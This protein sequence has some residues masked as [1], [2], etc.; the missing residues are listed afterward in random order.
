MKKSCTFFNTYFKTGI[1][2]CIAVILFFSGYKSFGQAC[3]GSIV[4]DASSAPTIDGIIDIAWAKA[5]ATQI[6][7]LVN[8]TLQSDYSAQWRAMY[9]NSF[10]YV[11]IEVKDAGLKHDGTP[12]DDDAIEI[13]VDGAHNGGA[14]YDANDFKFGFQLQFPTLQPT[15]YG[16]G[17]LAGVS[18]KMPDVPGGYLLE[19]AIP[20]STIGGVATSGRQIGFDINIHDD[21]N[22]GPKEATSGWF[23]TSNQL[24]VNPG[25]FGTVTL[26][27]CVNPLNLIAAHTDPN[28]GSSADGT[29]TLSGSNGT[30]PYTYS[31]DGT[32]FVS[33]GNFT[34]L[35]AGTYKVAVKDGTG[36]RIDSTIILETA[37]ST[38]KVNNDTT[39]CAGSPVTLSVSGGGTY[40]WTASP[41]D[42][43]LTATSSATPTVSPI[44]TTTYTVTSPT[45]GSN[46]IA[47]SGFEGG[48]TG[49]TTDYT[50][51]TG[52]TF[53]SQ[54]YSI[55]ANPE[56]QNSFFTTCGDHTTGTGK[57]M[58]IDGA[59][60]PS[61]KMWRQSVPV[62]PN[63]NYVFSY[64]MQTV[65]DNPT[66]GDDHPAK[67]DTK[68][69]GS[70][71]GVA[72]SPVMGLPCGNW[73][74]KI[75]SWNSGA[76]TSADIII[77]DLETSAGGN[78]FAID[79]ISFSTGCVASKT[80]TITI[81]VPVAPSVSVTQPDCATPTGA[82]K[83]T[84]T[85]AGA[86]YSFNDGVSFQA[87]PTSLPLAQNATY[88]V[89]VKNA[90]GCVSPATLVT[91]ISQ[92]PTPA[93]P[94][95]DP[96]QPTCT[97]STGSIEVTSIAVGS[98]YSFDNG[99]TFQ[100]SAISSALAANT[101]YQVKVQNATGCISPAS[102][103]AINAQPL[104][105]AAPSATP[106]QPTCTT[107]T[108]TIEVTSIAAGLTYSFDNG[109][110][111][112]ASSISDPLPANT[113]YQVKVKN[114]AGC[115]SPARSVTLNAQP[116]AIAAPTT[117]PTHPTCTTSTGTIEVTS[118]ATGLT[119]SFDNGINFQASAISSALNGGTTYQAKVKNASGC[120]SPATP[121]T[122]NAQPLTPSAPTTNPTQPTCTTAT[123]TIEVTSTVVGST[124]SFDNGINFKSSAISNALNGG[125]T[126]Q[127][128]VKNLSGCISLAS[129]VPLNAQ[130]LTPLAPA[131]DP[132]QPTCTTAQGIIEVT[133]TAAGSTYSFDNGINFQSSSISNALNGGTTYQVKI[134]NASGCISPAA[135]V[136]LNAQPL[137]PSAP[138]TNPT[139][140][141][142]TTATGTIE[143]TSTAVGSTYSFDNGINFQASAI[144][145]ALNGG[146]TYQVK[147]KT[148]SGCISPASSVA[149]NNAPAG[150]IAPTTNPIHPTCTMATGNIEVT[151]IAAGSSYSFDNGINF[152]SSAIS[153]ALPGN[154]IY[155]VKIKNA[156]GCISPASSVALNAQPSTP[157]APTTNLV[158]PTCTTTTGTI[159]VTSIAAGSSYSFDNGINFQSSAI[160]NALP[161]N[162]TY[163][164]KV[165]NTAG[166][167]SPASSVALNA[168]P[169]TPLAPT[170][171]KTDPTCTTPT[172][173]IEVTSTA[174]GSTYSFDNGINF[175]TS[176]ISSPLT[177][178]ATYQ[179]KVKNISGCISPATSV[180]LGVQPAP[181]SPPI[182]MP[183]QPIC[184]TFTGTIEVTSAAAGLTYSFDNGSNFQ[185]SSISNPLPGGA[186]YQ[187][188]VKTDAGCLS[189]ATPVTL[190]L[191][192]IPSAPSV[193]VNQ[194]TCTITTGTIEVTSVAT[195]LTYSFDNGI[196]FQSANI[197]NLLT[198][199]NT[200]QVIVKNNSG[201]LSAPT[202]ATINPQPLTPTAPATSVEEPN[203]TTSTGKITVTSIETGATYSFDN[204]VSFQSSAIS[205][206][207]TAG[208]SYQVKIKSSAGCISPA[209]TASISNAPASVNAPST[210]SV[211]YCQNETAVSLAT[212]A[213]GTN[214]KW[215][216]NPVGGIGSTTAPTPATTAPLTTSYF[217]SQ[218]DGVCES[219]RAILTVMVTKS[220][221]AYAGGPEVRFIEGDPVRLK[222][223]ASG[224][225]ITIKWSPDIAISSTS[226]VQPVVKPTTT[227]RY[228]MTV[229]TEGGCAAYDT[230]DVIL[231]ERV[232]IPNIFSP[233][234]D[235][236]YDKWIIDKI[237][238]YP[239]AH[240]KIFNRYGQLLS[241]SVGAIKPWDGTYQ[242][243]P[244]P[245]GAYYYVIKLKDEEV[246][247]GGSISLIR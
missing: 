200:Y 144:S 10:L 92:P 124:Y 57:M 17:S 188:K 168:Q 33:S 52:S 2:Y 91:L 89:K 103:V 58:V 222:G 55:N 29:M 49:F 25:L 76:S 77:Y 243:K 171:S 69:N 154:I 61:A 14:S 235:G 96:T 93:A 110:N 117:D 48:N 166:C 140:P 36:I 229:T 241:E 159:E 152:Q 3:T 82:I 4:V 239:T 190:V 23:S 213:S 172:G 157:L 125:T 237:D 21:D 208:V 146:S 108:G 62:I 50:Y 28:C 167:I 226:I 135:S 78:D 153:N 192:P 225:N 67:L 47:N 211:V 185:S 18:A 107:A 141:T 27:Q 191:L 109:A 128:K 64:W 149:L 189:S 245:V 41:A 40:T 71:L 74:Q 95:T 224:D 101:T 98:T 90:I 240:V 123:G 147:V 179:V 210:T 34:G 132:T 193:K 11:L 186:T 85:E 39:V 87:S 9:D 219:P 32:T 161:G 139:H 72:T 44:V 143:V 105:P 183:T 30:T 204:G 236:I 165:K 126:Y 145:N 136:S 217:V 178:G 13:F 244:V 134:K 84:S 233:N 8:G 247:I 43:T 221:V 7:K 114:A 158:H 231:V 118:T 1:K 127:V 12:S 6:T 227:I 163:Q 220:P 194:P 207:L 104:T 122:L 133:S 5:P 199:G 115:I 228:Y 113:T 130:P 129:S 156:A 175:Q 238:Q 234:G 209:M 131:T 42:P 56:I 26:T 35:S 20:W 198:A 120:I 79:D 205:S 112:Q 142:C 15:I 106:T 197:S 59:A 45:V 111:F 66:T 214:L 195:G 83:V 100:S 75:Y 177:G 215:Y 170:V 68:I 97:T 119:Y 155:Q 81:D 31:K 212:S 46:L 80:V 187:V 203:C 151:S 65:A 184:T 230:V 70:S 176:A 54:T 94:A 137:P 116:G 202:S 60:N 173:T 174:A 160:S 53:S 99:V 162:I 148:A 19:V 180:T 37:G 63:S 182:A 88:K 216:T 121:T 38:L 138:T 223:N 218:S 196:N 51:T 24:S 73:V 102:S 169:S 201:C 206:P 16:S 232:F 150:P 242:G 22:G 86:T 181:P 246:P 164:V